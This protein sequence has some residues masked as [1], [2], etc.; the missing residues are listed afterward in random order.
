ME[1][2]SSEASWTGDS[3][4]IGLTLRGF[5][6]R[7]D[8]APLYELCRKY[9]GENLRSWLCSEQTDTNLLAVLHT[10]TRGVWRPR[11]LPRFH[12]PGPGCSSCV[13]TRRTP[14]QHPGLI[15]KTCCDWEDKYAEY[16]VLLVRL[17]TMVHSFVSSQWSI[18]FLSLGIIKSHYSSL[19]PWSVKLDGSWWAA[20]WVLLT[21]ALLPDGCTW[22]SP[23]PDIPTYVPFTPILAFLL[24]CSLL[25]T[26]TWLLSADC[27][28][29]T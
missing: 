28:D 13:T 26:R 4:K 23:Y 11:R 2:G 24:Q 6:H 1:K 22:L 7:K 21:L 12:I 18:V 16:Q 15:S 8:Y 9:P 3:Q 14:W 29:N 27:K 25:N 5:G 20:S 10:C 17:L 19:S